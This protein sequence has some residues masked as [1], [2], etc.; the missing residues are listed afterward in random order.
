MAVSPFPFLRKPSGQNKAS[1]ATIDRHKLGHALVLDGL[2][3]DEQLAHALNLQSTFPEKRLGEIL[4]EAKFVSQDQM[5]DTL[6]RL[7]SEMHLPPI[8]ES[9]QP[10]VHLDA[11]TLHVLSGRLGH[12]AVQSWLDEAKRA[13]GISIKVE[14]CSVSDLES[15][16]STHSGNDAAEF[17]AIRRVRQVVFEGVNRKASDIHMT[18]TKADGR[19]GLNVQYRIDGSLEDGQEFPEAE[20][21]QMF[22]AMFQGMAAVQDATVRDLE[23]QN[24][25][26][27]DQSLLRG[28]AG[29][30]LGLSGIRLARAPLY[31]GMNL[32][33]R[34]L[35]TQSSEAYGDERLGRLGYSKQQLRVLH[36]LARRTVGMNPITGPTGSGKSTTLSQEIRTILDVREG[37][38]IITIE[39]PIEYEFKHKNVWQYLIANANT[40]E[41]KSAAFAGALKTALRQDPDIIMVGEIRGLETAREAINA[42]LTGHQVWTTLHVDDPF[43]IPQRLIAMGIDGY[44]LTDPKLLSSLIA[45][46]LVK[47]MCPHCSVPWDGGP[48]PSIPDDEADHLRAW[49]PLAPFASGVRLRG[50]GCEHCHRGYTGRS[51]V[52]QVI[53]TD[54]NL[55]MQMID[56]G[57]MRARTDY[58]ARPDCELDMMTH[59]MLKVL[60]GQVDPRSLIEV[61][62]PIEP[63]AERLRGLTADD[64]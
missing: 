1:P 12:P 58:M 11:M 53:P 23:S 15:M 41:D 55:L 40:D 64:I 27:V 13:T 10:Y 35:Y 8:P 9:A 21:A 36:M 19:G 16:R 22:R 52:A 57:P 34:L 62:G 29:Q 33:A 2:I 38:R 24:A 31:S 59:G 25:I 18:L 56:Q 32:A 28:P 7:M 49:L 37:V 61:L 63:P 51:V 45:Q 5:H 20:G 39:D 6:D 42:A 30:N 4:V 14:E 46:R 50:S 54:V 17:S 47:V 60:D 26:I 43:M 3:T 48:I 44:F